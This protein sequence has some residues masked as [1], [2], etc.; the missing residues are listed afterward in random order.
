MRKKWKAVILSAVMLTVVLSGCSAKQT[1]ANE[2]ETIHLK[3]GIVN[4]DTTNYY[5]SK[6][7]AGK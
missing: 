4:S 3:F 5:L 1:A 6:R 7:T 2:E